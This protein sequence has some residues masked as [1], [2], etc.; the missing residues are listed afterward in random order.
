MKNSSQWFF[1]LLLQSDTSIYYV[2][3]VSESFCK[4][5]WGPNY[6]NSIHADTT[7]LWTSAGQYQNGIP[8]GQISQYVTRS[9]KT[10]HNDAFLEID[11]FASVCFMYLKLCSVLIGASLSE[12]H[13][14][15][16][17]V[18]SSFYEYK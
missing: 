6:V 17:F 15:E 13:T 3:C 1:K 2:D 5:C 14:S 16:T 7:K 12:P 11:I 9:A 8:S 10:R 18:G 4:S